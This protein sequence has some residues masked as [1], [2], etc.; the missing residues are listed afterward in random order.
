MVTSRDVA[1]LAGV[2]QATV[3]RV[4]HDNPK[5]DEER[6]RRVL[7]ALAQTGY[8]ANAHA[9]AMRMNRTGIIGV[10]AGHITN[11]FYPEL[12][13]SLA[14][15]LTQ[16]AQRM[17]L[18]TSSDSSEPAAI[19]AVRGRA[20]DGLIFTTATSESQVLRAAIDAR[21]PIVLV[22]RSLDGAP[23]DQ[24][25]SDNVSGG[26]MVA[27]YFVRSG[28]SR[29][30]VIGGDA[31]I[32]TGQERRAGF[33]AKLRE[34][35]ID[36]PAAMAPMTDFSHAAGRAAAL[37][38][39]RSNNRPTAVFCVNDLLAFGVLDAVRESGLSV[40]AD[41]WVVG[42]DDVE[43]ARWEAF[44]LTTVRQPTNEMARLVVQMLLHRLRE[45]GRPFAHRRFAAE[46]IIRESTQATEA[47]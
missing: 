47:A 42:Y 26:G 40:P 18:W 43:M 28:H 35:G 13:D 46:L 10:V 25:T 15:A 8:V 29:V 21:A 17:I 9:R 7:E 32:S 45:P 4:L 12:I 24:V 14:A 30:A 2:S 34:L 19:D 31:I 5:V 39:L 41:L 23:C 16:K 37:A 27:D 20:V 3:S 36:I 11:P 22:N 38:L 33:M 1:R 44:N 6:R